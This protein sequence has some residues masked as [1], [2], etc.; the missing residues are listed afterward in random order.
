MFDLGTCAVS[1]TEVSRDQPREHLHHHA[2]QAARQRSV[3]STL[4][5]L[6]PDEC[7]LRLDLDELA[8]SA[9]VLGRAGD[10]TR[11]RAH[12]QGD[13]SIVERVPDECPS[14][15]VDVRV[16]PLMSTMLFPVGRRD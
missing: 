6:V 13:A 4:G 16:L 8:E 14:C 9:L 12:T 11:R 7:V 10:F 3:P 15:T 2:E 1:R 5:R